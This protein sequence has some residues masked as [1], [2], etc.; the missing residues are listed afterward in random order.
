MY[1]T[2]GLF[3]ADSLF[4]LVTVQAPTAFRISSFFSGLLGLAIPFLVVVM[5]QRRQNWARF[6]YAAGVALPLLIIALSPSS[7]PRPGGTFLKIGVLGVGLV[8]L[9]LLFGG[10]AS[11]W[12]YRV[13]QEGAANGDLLRTA[14]ITPRTGGRSPARSAFF[15]IL[16]T[17]LNVLFSSLALGLLTLVA[18]MAFFAWL[19]GPK[20]GAA[21]LFVATLL[22][23]AAACYV[24]VLK[25]QRARYL[26]HAS[27]K[28]LIWALLPVPFV[29]LAMFSLAPLMEPLHWSDILT[30][31]VSR[32]GPANDH[33]EVTQQKFLSQH[34]ASAEVIVRAPNGDYVI[35]GASNDSGA[36]AWATR[37]DSGGMRRWEYVDGSA[38]S[39]DDMTPKDNNIRG[40]VVLDDNSV[41]LCGSHHSKFGTG[42]ALLVR[43]DE[44]QKAEAQTLVPDGLPTESSAFTACTRWG[45]GIALVGWTGSIGSERNWLIKLTGDRKKVWTRV[46]PY[47]ADSI[48]ETANHQLIL[49]KRVFGETHLRRI[50]ESGRVLAE[51]VVKALD[52][53]FVRSLMPSDNVQFLATDTENSISIH[54]F[55]PDFHEQQP[56]IKLPSIL[57]GTGYELSDGSL[58]IFGGADGGTT[59][60]VWRVYQNNQWRG[61]GLGRNS[62]YFSDAVPAGQ[63]NSFAAVRTTSGLKPDEVR[64]VLAFVSIRH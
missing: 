33:V 46:G 47:E 41:L 3:F 52:G 25:C 11:R 39:W 9:I 58:V 64:P 32:R 34:R 13:G 59:G 12:F 57:F 21:L 31:V 16:A 62:R 48:L 63:A 50:D 23:L 4:R 53:R 44:S 29:I 1:G 26:G 10:S 14:G 55:G 45:N 27:A 30:R 49:A 61:V 54:S 38:A 36:A 22:L 35:A 8:P 60:S 2:L 40:V 37:V 51:H 42:P 24:S 19:L 6:L 15:G 56:P 7:M 18:L 17:V 20:A 5:I 43:I 28:T